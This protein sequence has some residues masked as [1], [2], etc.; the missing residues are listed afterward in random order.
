MNRIVLIGNGFDLAHGLKTSYRD[1]MNSYWTDFAQTVAKNI[2]NPYED[3]LVKLGRISGPASH[4]DV[5]NA[6]FGVHNEKGYDYDEIIKIFCEELFK[7]GSYDNIK[8]LIA[9]FNE[10][11]DLNVKLSFKNT[12]FEHIS[13][14]TCVNTWVDFENEYYSLLKQIYQTDKKLYG[15][16]KGLNYDLKCLENKLAAYLS[17]IQ[18][19]KINQEIVNE[20]LKNK[21]FTPF[22]VKDIS[23]SGKD[24]FLQFIKNR[25]DDARDNVKTKKFC[26]KYGDSVRMRWSDILEYIDQLDK[27]GKDQCNYHMKQIFHRDNAWVPPYFHLPEEILFLNFNYTNT[28]SLYALKQSGFRV[29]PIHGEL[30][31]PDNP[32]IFGYGDEMDENYKAIENLN[33]NDYLQNIKSIR[34]LETDNY[35][36]LLT[37]I[38]SAPYQIIIMGHSCGNSDRTLLNTL[39]EHENCLSIKPYFHQ[40]EDG[41]D[42]YIDIV[43]NIS[44]NFKDMT[45]MR[46]RV[47]N[48]GYCEAMPQNKKDDTICEKSTL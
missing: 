38:D 7:L 39:F 43:Q 33:D 47:V 22:N 18:E 45:L 13:E 23:V 16:P 10:A 4:M 30:N 21:A 19:E 14:K 3:D 44:R 5:Y 24:R 11:S 25:L 1:F 20:Q 12:L 40:K 9:E 42:N 26:N 35:R 2:F 48:K 31:N 37:F 8:S 34:Y 17:R 27:S 15:S 29:N 36:K 6:Q 28:A 32:I 46:D 41:S